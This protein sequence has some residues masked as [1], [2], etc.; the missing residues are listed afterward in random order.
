MPSGRT[1]GIDQRGLPDREFALSLDRLSGPALQ[2]GAKVLHLAPFRLEACEERVQRDVLRSQSVASGGEDVFRDPEPRRDDERVAA[3]GPV[4]DETV[5]RLEPRAIEFQRRVH[6]RRLLV[7]EALEV[8]EVRRGHRETS[9][10]RQPPERRRREGA[11]L[12]RI[13]RAPDLVEEDDVPV[14]G[15]VQD[16]GQVARLR[17][18]GGERRIDRLFVA[19]DREEAAEEGG[20]RHRAAARPRSARARTRGP[21]S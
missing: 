6:G 10:P 9:L 20:S 19:D 17:T 21:A 18:E 13:R 2:L 5:R 11:P 8:A 12:G 7:P 14:S 4:P 3:T 1:L 16:F 15:L